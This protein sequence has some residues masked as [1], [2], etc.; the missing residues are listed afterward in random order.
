[1][2][3]AD[4]IVLI[5]VA[6]AALNGWRSGGSTLIFAYSGFFLGLTLGWLFGRILSGDISSGIHSNFV[7]LIVG[8]LILFLPAVLIGSVGHLL[9]LRIH[10][11]FKSKKLGTI[12]T[13]AGIVVA[14]VA[15]LIFCWIFASLM[16]NSPIQQLD[17]QIQN[18]R[19][20]RALNNTMPTLPL[21]GLRSVINDSGLPAV[22]NNFQPLPPGSVTES[23]PAQVQQV[24]NMDQQSM[25]KIVGQGCGQ[26]QE[27]SGFVVKP[28]Y[29]VTNAHVI[30]GIQ[31]P[32]VQDQAGVTHSTTVV[33][34]NPEYDLAV[35]Y[36]PH[37]NEPPLSFDL[38]MLSSGTKT[39]ILGYPEG[40]PFNAQPGGILQEFRAQGSDIYNQNTT[41]RNVYQVQADIRPGNS[42]GPLLT[43]SGQVAGIVFS[44]STTNNNVGYA[45][46]SSG[47]YKRVQQALSNPTPTSTEGCA[48]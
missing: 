16:A 44:R 45:L 8:M 40:G 5:L 20:L 19:I 17:S 11:W 31:N 30:A 35:M 38:N 37:L 33:Y 46:V 36:V 39:V 26:I 25:V 32:T 27:G 14:V 23:S 6:M 34:Y 7:K 1:M 13:A 28:D 24:V 22:F 18:S 21:D 41:V 2:N 4:I 12:D 43:L 29:V 9:G 47:V 15:T 42:G 48:S 3:L 10:S